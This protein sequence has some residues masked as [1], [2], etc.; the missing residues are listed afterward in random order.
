MS[1]SF[2][3]YADITKRQLCS[4]DGNNAL[5]PNLTFG[6]MVSFAV[7]LL[8]R[9]VDGVT[10]TDLKVRSLRAAIGPVMACP[11]VGK[12]ALKFAGDEPIDEPLMLPIDATCDAVLGA[13]QGLPGNATYPILEVKPGIDNGVWLLRFDHA[14]EVPI[15]AGLNRLLPRAFV[16]VRAFQ[17]DDRW[18]HELRLIVAPYVFVN[19]FYRVLSPPPSVTRIRAGDPGDDQTPAQNEVQ[20]IHV[21]K[22]FA[23]TYYVTFDY[24]TSSLLGTTDGPVEIAAALNAMWS[25]GAVRFLATLPESNEVYVEFVGALKASPQSMLSITV[26]TFRAGDMTFDLD[27]GNADL[28]SAMRAS[29]SI[30]VPL[31]VELEVVGDDEDPGDPDVVGK[32]MTLFSTP[33]VIIQEQIWK[34]LAT[35]PPLNWIRPPQPKNYIP[36]NASQ[37]ITGTQFY[38]ATIGNGTATVI[39]IDHNLGTDALHVTVRENA[40]GGHRIEDNDYAVAF[41]DTNSITLTFATAPAANSLAVVISTAGPTSA[42]ISGLLIELEQVNGLIPRLNSLGTRVGAIEELLPHVTPTAETTSSSGS[43]FDIEIPDASEMLPG[44]LASDFDP[45]AAAKDATKQPRA[46]GFLPAIHDA[47]IDD[48]AIPLSAPS[49]QTGKAFINNTDTP[50]LVPGGLGRRGSHLEPGGFAGSDGRVWYRLSRAGTT[51]SFYP[52]DL[53]RELFMLPLNE[54]M[55]GAGMQFKL[56]FKLALQ[57]FKATSRAQYTLVIEAGNTPGQSD[58]SPTGPN[59]QDVTWLPT[60]ILSRRI[61]V[62]NIKVTHPFGCAIRRDIDGVTMHADQMAYN[63]WTGGISGGAPTDSTFVLRARLIEFDT[64]NSVVGAKGLVYYAFSGATTEIQ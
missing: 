53:E 48:I 10:S 43:P 57:L 32:T 38:V 64:E 56:T 61:I 25:D 35:V 13:V 1:N 62:S 9:T 23:G 11:L 59:L 12:F 37:V 39:V 22:N 26:N 42:F 63:R 18:W 2:V 33:V 49:S 21:P 14:G 29:P 31:E 4:A 16:R 30:Q 6:D 36:Y 17:A 46:G 19:N 27:L 15:T 54:Q 47:T 5:L 51:N 24:R 52:T 50:I 40:S 60:P 7:R 28:A 41:T 20:K 3:I 8:D 58:P 55:L 45:D 44:N 34:E